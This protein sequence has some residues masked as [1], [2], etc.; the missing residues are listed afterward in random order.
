MGPNN[1]MEAIRDTQSDI[2]DSLKRLSK[3]TTELNTKKLYAMSSEVF[4][5]K[6]AA[7][8][9]FKRLCDRTIRVTMDGQL[10]APRKSKHEYHYRLFGDF[11]EILQ[12]DEND[13]LLEIEEAMESLRD[14]H[15]FRK[16]NTFEPVKEYNEPSFKPVKNRPP[17]P[18]KL[19]NLRELMDHRTS[20][21]PVSPRSLTPL[22]VS[23][24][25]YSS[26]NSCSSES[27]TTT[28]TTVRTS[29]NHPSNYY[30]SSSSDH[31]VY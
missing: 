14:L 13:R 3:F 12:Y 27:T 4:D 19:L 20:P 7:L 6:Q 9:Q 30:S 29:W 21:S 2:L 25:G 5:K 11:M 28:T 24:S 1:R 15:E 17:T 31:N 23:P 18:A 26:S 22:P 16:Q 8:P 10:L